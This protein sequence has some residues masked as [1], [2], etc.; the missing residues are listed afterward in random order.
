MMPIIH[1]KPT[2]KHRL[3]LTGLLVAVVVGCMAEPSVEPSYK[4]APS[5]PGTL[6]LKEGAGTTLQDSELRLSIAEVKDLTSGGCQGGP[7]GCPDYARITLST[8]N[9]RQEFQLY[10]A[11]TEA[12]RRQGANQATAFGYRITLTSVRQDEATLIFERQNR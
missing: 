1:F 7:Q 6:T 9:S 11:H 8:S 2:R 3:C 10:I 12:Q 5:R 4:T